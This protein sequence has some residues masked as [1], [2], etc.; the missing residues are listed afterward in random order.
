[1]GGGF[2]GSL[3]EQA[4]KLGV[5]TCLGMAAVYQTHQVNSFS[6]IHFLLHFHLIIVGFLLYSN[7]QLVHCLCD[8]LVV[9]LVARV[10]SNTGE[11]S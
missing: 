2:N 3:A 5:G 8:E 11:T 10:D 6:L 1:M 4:S 9:T 7:P